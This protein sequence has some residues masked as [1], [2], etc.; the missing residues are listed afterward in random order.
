MPSFWKTRSLRFWVALGMFLALA[1]ITVSAVLGH[2][3]LNRGVIEA[4]HD[5]STR[6]VEQ[7]GPLQNL[8]ILIWDTLVPVDEYVDEGGVERPLLYR[9]LRGQIESAFASARSSLQGDEAALLHLDNALASWGLADTQATEL[10]SVYHAPGDPVAAQAMER[11]HG[12]ISATSDRLGQAYGAIAAVMEGDHQAAIDLSERAELLFG[13][14]L[15]LSLV[16][17]V[18]GVTI[19]GIIMARSVDRLVDGATRFA[20][21]DRH[22]RIEISVPPELNRVA[23]EFNRMISRIEQSETV[24]ADLARIDELTQLHNRRAFDEALARQISSVERGGGSGAL[25]TLDIDHFKAINDT[26]GHAAGDDVLR[27]FASVVRA[28]LRPTDQPHRVGGEEFAIILPHT[29]MEPA[30]ALADSVRRAIA[31]GAA[32]HKGQGIS[33]TVSIGVAPI[34]ERIT[35]S[36]ALEAADAALYRAKLAGRNRVVSTDKAGPPEPATLDGA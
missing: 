31:A 19:I 8:R 28:N 29:D 14:A 11:F 20:G 15:V 17:V 16:A 18:G 35:P 36:A 25:L 27:Y 7:V 34:T 5:V 9:A 1:P 13:A 10:I 12:H 21:G 33:V 22:H 6:Q 23:Q 3:V 2:I 30:I 4:F 32:T 24:L 26:Y